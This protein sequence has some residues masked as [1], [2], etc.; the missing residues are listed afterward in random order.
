M[1]IFNSQFLIRNS[2]LFT[3]F[4][5]PFRAVAD[6]SADGRSA[7]AERSRSVRLPFLIHLS[8]FI[9]LS[10]LL[11][12]CPEPTPP[13]YGLSLEA[14]DIVC[15][16]AT[17]KV[18]ASIDSTSTWD[19]GLYR[20]DSLV[21]SQS[22][23]GGSGYLRDTGL[24]PNESYSY[25]IGYLKEGK[26]KDRSQVVNITTL[27]TTSSSFTWSE[28][29]LFDE[30][31]DLF[32]IRFRTVDI[33]SDDNIWIGGAFCD[34]DS[35]YNATHWDGN[36]WIHY[37]FTNRNPFTD[38]IADL[39]QINDDNLWM[40]HSASPAFLISDSLHRFFFYKD[41]P[42]LPNR[43]VNTLWGSAPDDVWFGGYDGA[44]YHWDGVTFHYI[45]SGT[46]MTIWDMDGTSDGTVYLVA[47]ND[48][49]CSC[50]LRIKDTTPEIVW[51]S[52]DANEWIYRITVIE[53]VPHL[54]SNDGIRRFEPYSGT[55]R[56]LFHDVD[57]LFDMGP[58]RIEISGPS[59][60]DLLIAS[61][62]K[63]MFHYNGKRLTL[64]HIRV[65][66]NCRLLDMDYN[67]ITYLSAGMKKTG[68][69]VFYIG[70]R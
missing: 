50:L 48:Q 25:H 66:T 65:D 9:I 44:I 40:I 12:S 41:Y 49:G 54:V 21:I 15:T 59:R 24:E 35:F 2:K 58:Y 4:R 32:G 45:H 64:L 20:D 55:M 16:E 39:K 29:F 1:K 26:A 34:N 69:P 5:F 61:P 11:S 51:E 38:I 42:N 14:V 62:W 68:Q 22:I 3:F 67:G 10:A 53:D 56:L 7:V 70:G 19:C 13:D 6:P 23:S 46:D 36:Q 17:F 47:Y 60:N 43:A 63:L 18:S 37:N 33:V 28:E 30:P 52:E 57:D 27:D 8:S 31:C